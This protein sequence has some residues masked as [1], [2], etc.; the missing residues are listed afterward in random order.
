MLVYPSPGLRFDERNACIEHPE[1]EGP[2][3]A[4]VQQPPLP[5]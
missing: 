5:T 1:H 2:F 4:W 3:H